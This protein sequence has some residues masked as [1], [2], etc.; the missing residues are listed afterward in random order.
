MDTRR[1]AEGRRA[2][3]RI[4][5]P[6]HL[7]S[8]L[9]NF[10]EITHQV[11][12]KTVVLFLDFDGTLTPIV[13]RPEQAHLPP[14]LR[15]VLASLSE[16]ATVAVV[17]GRDR[18]DVAARVGLDSLFYAGSHGFDISGPEGWHLKHQ[19]GAEFLP[20]LD[21]AE[22][23]LRERLG[24][25]PGVGVERKQFGIAAHYRNVNEGDVNTVRQAVE[26]V[27]G[28]HSGELRIRTGKKVLELQPCIDWNKG[29]AVTWLL[30]ALQLDRQQ[31]APVYIGDDATDEDAFWALRHHGIGILVGARRTRDTF[32]RYR[33][34]SPSQVRAFLE[35]LLLH[36]K[37]ES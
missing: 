24:D 6:R 19:R 26:S 21:R 35:N 30:G 3:L 31:T 18:R 29:K 16:H 4:D 36:V 22:Q 10:A 25:L 13:E 12:A 11:Q 37:K 1:N 2:Q 28:A 5:V 32:A 20:A 27:Y 9:D 15:P 23:Q 8:A 7:P 34:E 33:L 14:E 17:S